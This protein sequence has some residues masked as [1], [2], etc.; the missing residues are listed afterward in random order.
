MAFKPG[1]SGNPEG[2]KKGSQNK[3]TKQVKEAMGMLLEGNLDNL[4]IWLAQIAADDPAKAM[5][6]VI[7]LS[8]R[9]V[10]KL[11]QQQITGGDGED[12]FK[13]ISFKFGN[14]TEE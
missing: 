11:S 3:Y 2:R 10:P 5:D 7:R 6:I 8:E 12:L 9:F 14:D 1:Q 13:N 4:S